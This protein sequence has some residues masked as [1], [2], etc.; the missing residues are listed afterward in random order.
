M[1]YDR[2]P[3]GEG[4]TQERIR[5]ENVMLN[6]HTVNFPQRP[7]VSQDAKEFISRCNIDILPLQHPL[8]VC[9]VTHSVQADCKGLSCEMLRM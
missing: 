2:R 1:L 4:F 8:G 7:T 6:A 5:D 3:F 9:K